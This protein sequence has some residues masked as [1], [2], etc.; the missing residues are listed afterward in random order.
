[1]ARLQRWLAHAAA[2]WS[3]AAAAGSYD[4]R[5][6]LLLLALT[7]L[8]GILRF[9]GV[10]SY[11]LHAPDEATTALPALHILVDGVP[12]FPSGMLY[13]RAMAHLYTLA[14]SVA[15]FGNSEWSLRLPSVLC[16]T[17]LVPLSVLLGR[18][19]LRT[20][21]SLAF[22]SAVAFLP[23]LIADSQV[24]RMYIFLIAT[25]VLYSHWIFRW[26]QTGRAGYLFATVLTM[27]V[28]IHFHQLA[29]F[30]SLVLFMPPLLS[31]DL[32]RLR[33]ACIA[34]V[35]IVLYFVYIRWTP[36]PYPLAITDFA[37][38]DQ[39][40]GRP[41][42]GS[43]LRLQPVLTAALLGLGLVTAGVFVR[44]SPERARAVWVALPLLGAAL[45]VAALFY[46]VAALLLIVAA[47]AARRQQRLRW[48]VAL[49][50]AVVLGLTAAWQL[51]ELTLLRGLPLRKALGV[52]VG[53]PSVWQYV[54][55]ASFSPGAM[56]IA[57]VGGVVA[58]WRLSRRQRLPAVC[59]YALL[60]II[61]PL[62]LMGLTDW[63]FPPRYVEFAL[64]PLL[65]VACAMAQAVADRWRLLGSGAAV[66]ATV[67]VLAII[68]PLATARAVNAG[69]SYAD[70][71]GAARYI[72]SRHPAGRDIVIA[73]DV[74]YAWYYLGHVD[75]WLMGRSVARNFAERVD[76]QVV[77]QYT[78][79][80]LIGTAE[81]LQALI[82]R[83]DRGTI[84]ILGSGEDGD[85]R[86]LR[87]D[88][89]ADLLESG[90][91]ETAFIGRDGQ[92]RVWRIPPSGA[93]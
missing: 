30:G 84:Y 92:T 67:A 62:F 88:A 53:Q 26:E 86:S 39:Q 63:F 10:G 33:A 65:V 76:G 32:R 38:D 29:I 52:M 49:L 91:F 17:L 2:T 64:L 12:R 1:M 80:P 81:E 9:W 45:A 21:W 25:L 57:A 8:A 15:I 51:H 61:L 36:S 87:G 4:L 72:Q 7:V 22:A 31:G 90:Q 56:L 69:D 27:C 77:Y 35:P 71:R 83:P 16:G 47:V 18:R 43:M 85:R 55:L 93:R 58:L 60:A 70:H 40:L 28:G 5:A 54:A 44:R 23:G 37:T 42:D 41:A 48:Q 74:L 24:V 66:A 89:I 79:T 3:P 14:G 13:T 6:R 75:Y 46:H 82:D 78:H 50:V 34:Y 11:G 68:N 19:F 59:L 20:T 73:E